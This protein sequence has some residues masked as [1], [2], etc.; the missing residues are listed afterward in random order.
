MKSNPVDKLNKRRWVWIQ[1][2]VTYE[3]HCDLCGGSNITWS[4]YQ[5]MIWCYDCRKDTPGFPGIFGGPIPIEVSHLLG[6]CFE[7]IHLKTGRIMNMVDRKRSGRIVWKF[8]KSVL[9][10][11]GIPL[12]YLEVINNIYQKMRK[13]VFEIK[14]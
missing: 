6:I 1:S 12:M 2:P 3:C 5:H 14:I 8:D 10:L 7:R 9:G 13:E 4:E 11:I